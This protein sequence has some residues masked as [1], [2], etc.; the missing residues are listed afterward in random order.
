MNL[1]ALEAILKVLSDGQKHSGEALGKPLFLSDSAV[2]RLL[3]FV[4][5]WGVS[6]QSKPGGG[7]WIE[8]GLD[9]LQEEAIRASMDPAEA[10]RLQGVNTHFRLDSTNHHLS[11]RARE[12]LQAPWATF[13]EYQDAGRGRHG[14]TWQ[15]PFASGLCMSLLWRFEQSPHHLM[16]MSLAVGVALADALEACGVPGIGLHWPNDLYWSE[17]KLGGILIELALEANGPTQCIIGTG[18]NIQVPPDTLQD[19]DQPWVDL[20]GTGW[21]RMPRSRL[22]G[23]LLSSLLWA[24]RSFE[25]KG[26]E[27]FLESWRRR[28]VLAGHNIVLQLGNTVVHGMASGVDPDGALRVRVGHK[29]LRFTSGSAIRS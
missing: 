6:V 2:R 21:P 27:P 20:V 19:L 24:M 29:M 16:G 26:L 17:R 15:S 23:H 12:G 25:E 8:G 7:Y 11:D 9:L 22:A 4:P 28:D 14:K 13:S 3:K 5:K 10:A 1:R 18:L